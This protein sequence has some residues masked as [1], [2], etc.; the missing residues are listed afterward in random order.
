MTFIISTFSEYTTNYKS[1]HCVNNNSIAKEFEC[2]QQ[3]WLYPKAINIHA[4]TNISKAGEWRE[5]IFHLP[6][7]QHT[8]IN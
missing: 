8:D 7:V 1:K 6:N 4:N 5:F 2:R 3:L